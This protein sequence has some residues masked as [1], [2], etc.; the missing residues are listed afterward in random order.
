MEPPAGSWCDY[1]NFTTYADIFRYNDANTYGSTIQR[2]GND[3]IT[4]ETTY[5]TNIGMDLELWKRV[6][7]STDLYNRRSYGLLQ[8]VQLPNLYRFCYT[9]PEYR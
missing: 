5:T 2:L 1:L 8:S 6:N 7:L 3:Q 9:D 4:W